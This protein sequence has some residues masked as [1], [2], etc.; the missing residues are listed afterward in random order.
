MSKIL[1]ANSN[2][3][4][5]LG[6]SKTTGMQYRNVLKNIYMEEKINNNVPA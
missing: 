5:E 1:K 6:P 3:H 4:T 2:S